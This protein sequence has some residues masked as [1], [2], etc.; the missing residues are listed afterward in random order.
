MTEF[1]VFTKRSRPISTQATVSIQKKG[2][3]ALNQVAYEMLG[4]PEAV[5]LL[6]KRTER[7]MG[8]RAVTKDMRHGYP[9]RKQQNSQSYL[10]AGRAFTQYYNI[11]VG[12]TRRYDARMEGDVLVVDVDNP[13]Q[14]V[15]TVR[16]RG[17]QAAPQDM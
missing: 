6:F 1:E 5:E 2:N 15:V 10:L 3:F 4:Q 12:V 8:L 14:E 7:I 13:V 11:D 16:S 17:I 9:V